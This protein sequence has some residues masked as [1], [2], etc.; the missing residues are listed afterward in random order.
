[1]DRDGDRFSLQN[2]VQSMMISSCATIYFSKG[3]DAGKHCVDRGRHWSG[4]LGA[5]PV[6]HAQGRDGARV[7]GQSQM[8][9]ILTSD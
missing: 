2:D 9:I 8:F 7:Q 1:M 3:R 4:I 5:G 6:Q